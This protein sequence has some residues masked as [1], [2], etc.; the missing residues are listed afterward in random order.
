[1]DERLFCNDCKYL[2]TKNKRVFADYC[3][4]ASYCSCF[5]QWINFDLKC[6]EC[7]EK[8]RKESAKN[9]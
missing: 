3:A 6:E 7:L 5:N 9:V 8:N 1:M 4:N 2:T